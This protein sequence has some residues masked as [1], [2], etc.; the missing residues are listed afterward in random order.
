M[1]KLFMI[2]IFASLIFLT[3]FIY[4]KITDE[5]TNNIENRI[6]NINNASKQVI[7]TNANSYI[8]AVNQSLIS[9]MFDSD[10]VDGDYVVKENKI[11]NKQNA[12]IFYEINYSGMKPEKDS[13]ITIKDDQVLKA[14]IYMKNQKV[15]YNG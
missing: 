5:T 12:S 10:I 2:I 14:T 6:D 13:I 4:K 1:K 11:V 8:Q 15:E 9:S 3:I 7:N